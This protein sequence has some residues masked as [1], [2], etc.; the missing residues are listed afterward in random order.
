MSA[1][2][3]T[4][5]CGPVMMLVVGFDRSHF[6]G[7]IL[8]E[9]RRL[10]DEGVI[11][12]LDLMVVAKHENG[13]LE[14]LQES[15]LTTEE[16]QE[17]GA[18]IGALVGFGHGGE[19]EAYS[20]AVAGAAEEVAASAEQVPGDTA[21]AQQARKTAAAAKKT[22]AAATDKAVPAAADT[23]PAAGDTAPGA[24]DTIP[25]A[26]VA[27][28]AA[29]TPAATPSVTPAPREP[30]PAGPKHAEPEPIDLL[31]VAG[32]AALTRYAG[33]LAGAA[34]LVLVVTLVVRRRRRRR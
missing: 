2:E 32:G 13:D 20:A 19:E 6:K 18:I 4:R 15:E 16:A 1:G 24:T 26:T 14:A 10:S 17:L 3:Q 7:E 21:V 9:L 8:P 33:P 11:R 34:V 27:T 22:A 31:E 29:S 5:P 30:R 28:P 12:V 23:A 25:V